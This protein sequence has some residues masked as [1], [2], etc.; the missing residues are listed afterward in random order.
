MPALSCAPQELSYGMQDKLVGW[1]LAM[2]PFWFS[3]WDFFEGRRTFPP[4]FSGTN[5]S[6]CACHGLVLGGIETVH[7]NA[8]SE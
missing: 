3:S 2:L 6:M 4:C 8:V 5:V 1:G 7:L